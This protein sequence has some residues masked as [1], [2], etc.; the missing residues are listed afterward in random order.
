MVL[1]TLGNFFAECKPL[2]N[3]SQNQRFKAI[4]FTRGG[5]LGR[6][7]N[8]FYNSITRKTANR[9]SPD[10]GCIQ[11][12]YFVGNSAAFIKGHTAP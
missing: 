1:C 9:I 10:K 7:Q 5:G 8:N 6:F 12:V 2:V 4:L 11:Q 3:M